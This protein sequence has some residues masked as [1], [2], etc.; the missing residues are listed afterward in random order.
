M[1][2][3]YPKVI[4]RAYIRA[5]SSTDFW[6]DLL[7][8]R[9]TL[10]TSLHICIFPHNGFML[11]C[12]WEEVVIGRKDTVTNKFCNPLPGSEEASSAM[13]VLIWLMD[14]LLW[15]LA[16][17]LGWMQLLISETA[18]WFLGGELCSLLS[19][20]R[21]ITCMQSPGFDRSPSKILQKSLN[22]SQSC[23]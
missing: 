17:L 6:G 23:L 21:R 15:N 18:T 22:H 20:L 12:C 4:L 13:R 1:L 10:R 2:I 8:L 7:I 5:V 14:V 11:P 9:D 3:Q 19:V 16:Q